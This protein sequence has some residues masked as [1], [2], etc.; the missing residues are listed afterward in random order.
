MGASPFVQHLD[1]APRLPSHT[2]S[3]SD[4]PESLGETPSP[5]CGVSVIAFFNQEIEKRRFGKHP[6]L[7][8]R[9]VVTEGDIGHV[10]QRVMDVSLMRCC[11]RLNFGMVS[12][13]FTVNAWSDAC[14][15]FLSFVFFSSFGD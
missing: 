13:Y 5:S 11:L 15:S 4:R 8:H 10:L 9:A 14:L 12:H 2:G 3:G 7:T 1:N 6:E